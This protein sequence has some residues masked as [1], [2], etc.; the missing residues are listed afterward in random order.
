MIEVRKNIL[1]GSKILIY[2]KNKVVFNHKFNFQQ[3]KFIFKKE[4]EQYIGNSIK[5]KIYRQLIDDNV[6]HKCKYCDNS[7]KYISLNY[8]F[9]DYCSKKCVNQTVKNSGKF[10]TKGHIKEKNERGK[11]KYQR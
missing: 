10:T 9:T 5:E 1:L 11:V 4:I 2:R 3:K 6:I 8:G 7:T